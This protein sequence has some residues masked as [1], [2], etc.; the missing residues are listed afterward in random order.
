[1]SSDMMRALVFRG[2]AHIEEKTVPMPILVD[3]TDAIVRISICGLCGSDMHAF[4]CRENV[5]VGTIMGHEFVGVIQEVGPKISHLNIGDKVMSP[6]TTSC[7]ACVPCCSGLSARCVRSQVFGAI[8]QGKGLH[9]AQAQFIR[10]PMAESTLMKIPD[11][12]SEEK[13]LLLGDV[14]STGFYAVSNAGLTMDFEST[15][16][17]HRFSVAVV[18]CGPVGLMAVLAAKTLG[19]SRI[20]AVDSISGRLDKAMD[21]GATVIVDASSSSVVEAVHEI[22]E[23]IGADIVVEAV[24]LP[25][26]FDSACNMVKFGG[27]ISVAGCHAH[28]SIPLS[29][30]Y[31]KNLT[32]KSGRC[33]ARSYME[34]LVHMI[35]CLP[36]DPAAIITHR[37]PLTSDAYRI[38]DTKAHGCIKVVMDPWVHPAAT[39]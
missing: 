2:N 8:Q 35:D 39:T 38:F 24:G 31:D 4:H 34:K 12:L 19:A 22:T 16:N 20:I 15:T 28:A 30:L 1:M 26:A 25:S 7:G 13:A 10:V 9:G 32:I 36:Q 18:G 33:P 37:L 3:D 14:C 11:G 5:D 21:F 17:N 29:R 27:T 6:F 23:G